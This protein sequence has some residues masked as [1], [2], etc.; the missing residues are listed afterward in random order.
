MSNLEE[1]KARLEDART[2]GMDYQWPNRSI[3][4]LITQLEKAIEMAEYTRHT[5][6]HAESYERALGFLKGLE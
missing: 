4:Y 2:A 3:D 1:I 6:D 5:D